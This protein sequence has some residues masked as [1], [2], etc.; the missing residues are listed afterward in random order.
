[1]VTAVNAAAAT[2]TIVKALIESEIQLCAG[3]CDAGAMEGRTT[4]ANADR[5]ATLEVSDALH[6]R[7][8]CFTV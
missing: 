8:T 2:C 7:C 1:M 4:A 6:E 3:A 5:A